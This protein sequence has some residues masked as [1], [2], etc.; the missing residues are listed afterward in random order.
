MTRKVLGISWLHGRFQAVTLS[1][2]AVSASWTKPEPVVNDADFGPALAEAI[3]QTGFT[4][5]RVQIVIDHRS[6]LFHV[7]ETPPARGKQLQL[8]LGRLVAQN[9]FFE[10]RAA[11][12]QIALP[13]LKDRQRSLLALLPESLVR[14]LTD[15]CTTQRV[16]LVGVLPVAAVLGEH[17]RR[18]PARPDEIVV[19]AADLGASLHLL[20]GRGDGQVL[21]SR[22]VVLASAQQ[23]ERAVQEINRTLHY[24][25]QQFGADVSQLFVFGEQAFAVLKDL[26]IR[27]GLK[28]LP[29]PVAADPLLY[30]RQAA[31]TPSKAGLNLVSRAESRQQLRRQLAVAGI[32]ALLL[33]SAGTVVKVE[34]IVRAREQRA[35][36]T[37]RQLEA[38]ASAESATR[39]RQQRARHL[40]AL[41]HLVGTTNSPPVPELF[42]RYLAVAM[43]DTMRLNQLNVQRTTN[44][45]SFH[46]EGFA[47]ESAGGFLGSLERFEQQ[48]RGSVF[49]PRITDSTHH[50]LF[51]GGEVPAA[52]AVPG[53][54]N[55]GR[56][57][58]KTFFVTGAIE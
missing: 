52:T 9:R 49:R 46:F 16:Q 41:L 13:S 25:Q 27:Q 38:A 23:S 30:A 29:S 19:L 2:G 22:S 24:A 5:H 55:G 43:P 47:R 37:E 34:H 53:T 32:A 6:L 7:Q 40:T 4:G 11:W 33:G 50:R 54:P 14:E 10:E 17:L 8:L 57:D 15:A 42:A 39:E 36:A 3:Q 12:G 35:A 1:G 20:L 31:N 21:F 44:G 51:G 58:E 48:L 56:S 45:W 18:L 28:I 26:Q